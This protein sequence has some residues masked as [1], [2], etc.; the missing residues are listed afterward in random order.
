MNT[1]RII[2]F[3]FMLICFLLSLVASKKRDKTLVVFP[4]VIF[5]S[6]LTEF[7]VIKLNSRHL[8]YNFIYHIY[9]PIEYVLLS[10]YFVFN[11][12]S[13]STKKII[14][15]SIPV[16]LILCLI[17]SLQTSFQKHPG[18]QIN[19]EGLLL[20]TWSVITL[21]SIEV[22]INTVITSLSIFWIC[23]AL[24]IYHSGIFT[25]TGIYN[26]I[27]EKKTLL[28]SKLSFFIIQMS[29]YLLYICLSIAFICSLRTKK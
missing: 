21:F 26:Y 17:L 29:N 14:I 28:G 8:N 9:V 27:I 23:V 13:T 22:K 10:L 18:I 1:T 3:I 4:I 20:I 6:I 7:L 5:I 24:L 15:Y 19:L 16:Y 25:F 12:K 11:T 2:Y